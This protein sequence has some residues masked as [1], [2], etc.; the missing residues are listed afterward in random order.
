[1]SDCCGGKQTQNCMVCGEKLI[2]AFMPQTMQCSFCGKE[3]QATVY[4]PEGHYTCEECHGKDVLGQIKEI[5]TTT[6]LKDPYAIAEEMMQLPNLPSM[7]REHHFIVVASLLAALKNYTGANHDSKIQ[8][9]DDML[10][11]GWR[12]INDFPSCTCAYEGICGAG[13]GVGTVFSLLYGATCQLDKERTQTMR[14]S[15]AALQALA[16][17]G[18]PACCKQSTRTAL[19]TAIA[20]L[21]EMFDIKLPVKRFPKCEYNKKSSAVC[22]GHRC[23]YFR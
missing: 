4:C 6:T 16:N 5:A 7:G 14:A 3:V 15:N 11:E 1:M 10:E 21:R 18:S 9:K 13:I 2:Y 23:V 8:V 12:R 19:E 17:A 20:L 22:K